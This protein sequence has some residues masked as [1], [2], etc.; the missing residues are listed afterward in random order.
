MQKAA[1]AVLL[2]LASTAGADT[3]GVVVEG[4]SESGGPL[5]ERIEAWATEHGMKLVP[6]PLS[7]DAAKTLANCLVIDDRKC[8]SAV[9]DKRGKA[10]HVIYARI[11]SGSISVFWFQKHH[12]AVAQKLACE[13]CSDQLLVDVLA[14]LEDRSDATT[15]KEAPPDP[16]PEGTVAAPVAQ[17]RRAS[18]PLFTM[19]GG[20]AL[21]ATGIILYATSESPTGAKPEYLND[22]PL[23]TGVAIAGGVAIAVGAYFYFA[24]H[25]SA[26]TVGLV[27]GGA[28]A[29]WAWS[30]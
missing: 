24:R 25:D 2:A 23:G 19:G 27:R 13:P 26:P 18:W 3:L 11:D 15:R 6:A 10:E 7:V 29:G 21:V 5:R 1:L 30:W 14:K 28:S 17:P 12:G 8:A 16:E 9:V 4:S 20:A 22:R